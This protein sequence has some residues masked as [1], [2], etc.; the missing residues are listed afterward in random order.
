M[1]PL[2]ID[3]ETTTF[4]K[5]NSYAQRNKLCLV[6]LFDGILY[7]HFDIQ[8]TEH[9][10]GDQ[11]LQIRDILT[12]YDLLVGFNFKFDLSWMRRYDI[13]PDYNQ[14]SVFD[15]QLVD[16]I[17]G[18]QREAFPSLDDVS[19]KHDFVGK[20]SH[21]DDWVARGL[22]TPEF[23]REEFLAYLEQ[24]CKLTWQV[25]QQQLEELEEQPKLK[26]LCWNSCQ[27]LRV[28][29]EME[30]NGLKYDI[31]KSRRMGDEF[32]VEIQEIDT[33][34]QELAPDVGDKWNSNDWL[35][36]ILYG[37]CVFV[38]GVEEYSF[39]HKDG[40]VTQKSRKIKKPIRFE[41]LVEPLKG[42]K[43]KKEGFFSVDE[44]NLKHLKATG[45]AKKIIDLI[46]E[47]NKLE[48]KVGTYFHGIPKLYEKMDWSDNILHGQLTHA[49]AVTGRLSSS[50]PNQQNLD[51]EVRKCI[52]SRF[53]MKDNKPEF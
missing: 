39:T 23:P 7:R 37:G 26:R 19:R 18:G 10:F 22:D 8:W 3:V 16:F 49:A 30:W 45:K 36:A 9:P 29:A 35:S 51:K 15:T 38:D 14:C 28:T 6:G 12:R 31:D 13:I 1:R 20:A 40:R 2:C 32:L 24:D 27:D 41:R 25:F 43:L 50:K 48:K 34:L 52:V 33:Q 47:R 53:K 17:L 5:G 4:E 46:L 11:L 21:I 42:S 44:N